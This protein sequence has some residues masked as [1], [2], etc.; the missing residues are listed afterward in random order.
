MCNIMLVDLTKSY[1]LYAKTGWTARV[2]KDEQ[3]GWYVGFVENNEGIW[4]F[5][6]NIISASALLYTIM[7]LF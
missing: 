5:A 6:M 1:K 7:F 2:N 4:I 3:I